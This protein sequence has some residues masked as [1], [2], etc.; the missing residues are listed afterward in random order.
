MQT[1]SDTTPASKTMER[2]GWTLSGLVILFLL[3]DT[4]IK[5]IKIEPVVTALAELGYPDSVARPIGLIVLVCAVLY[6]M[7][8]TSIL[9]AVLLTG[10]LGGAIASHVRID[11]PLFSHTFFGVYLGI[12]AWG[13]L[14]LRDARLR[15]LLPVRR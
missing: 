1:A 12:L 5:L 13:G 7:P 8:K 4:T 10:L 9:G 11:S 6:A 15:A 2:I 14:F 3:F